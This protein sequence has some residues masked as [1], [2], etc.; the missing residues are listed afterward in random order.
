[1][2]KKS[3]GDDD[4]DDDCVCW[5]P[6]LRY[7]IFEKRKLLRDKKNECEHCKQQQK[8]ERTIVNDALNI[9]MA[10]ERSQITHR[11]GNEGV[12][13]MKQIDGKEVALFFSG[14]KKIKPKS[15]KRKKV[16][17][18]SDKFLCNAAG[19]AKKLRK[20]ATCNKS[21]SRQHTHT[22]THIRLLSHA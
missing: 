18:T 4:N 21:P 12:A 13:N 9:A 3:S 19:A 1:M 17:G 10:Y 16:R 6:W 8:N 14:K 5:S 22:H 7:T 11:C 2:L 20:S 15:S